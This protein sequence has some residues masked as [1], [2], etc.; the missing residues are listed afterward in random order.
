MREVIVF[1][2]VNTDNDQYWAAY[3]NI[4]IRKPPQLRGPLFNDNIF[5][6][7]QYI[8]DWFELVL[9]PIST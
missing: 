3:R 4:E 8:H 5:S 7:M 2:R 1:K 6:W 9:Y